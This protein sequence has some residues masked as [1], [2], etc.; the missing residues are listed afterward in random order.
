MNPFLYGYKLKLIKVNHTTNVNTATTEYENIVKSYFVEAQSKT[1]IYYI[2]H[3]EDFLF[4]KLTRNG[5]DVLYYI[6]YNL[7]KDSDSITL[8]LTKLITEMNSSRPTVYRGIGE[9]IEHSVIAK[10][11][12][13]GDYWI[14]PHYMFNGDRIKFI[15]SIDEDCLERVS[16]VNLKN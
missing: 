7:P 14:N 3:A 2:P 12:K 5:R 4:K 11:K 13:V 1:S 16:I 6:I 10:K 9:L 8:K 15:K